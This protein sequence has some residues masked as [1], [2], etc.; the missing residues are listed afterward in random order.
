LVFSVTN[1]P[2]DAGEAKATAPT[3]ALDSRDGTVKGR[4]NILLV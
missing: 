1:A 2:A 4:R 3:L